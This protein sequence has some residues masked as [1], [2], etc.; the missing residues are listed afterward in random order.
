MMLAGGGGGFRSTRT[1]TRVAVVT[2]MIATLVAAGT[3][4]APA[5]NA[6]PAEYLRDALVQARAGSSCGPL[7][8]DPIAERVAAIANQSY[9]EWLAHMSTTPPITDPLP[10][11]RELGYTGN[12]GKF[13]GG[14]S[15]KTEADAI[16]GVLLEG[17]AAIPD[18]SYTDYGVHMLW[19]EASG[20]TMAAVVLAGP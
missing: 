20:Y 3:P 11:L 9:P 7:N 13:L 19:D 16:K 4:S 15:K 18:C 6:D 8:P 5:A 1:A 10:G 12:K 2:T 17:Y 14:V